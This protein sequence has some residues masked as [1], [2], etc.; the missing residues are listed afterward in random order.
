MER[1]A[2]LMAN[3]ASP[4]ETLAWCP[5]AAQARRVARMLSPRDAQLA[6][7][8]AVEREDQ[9][10]EASGGLRS[11]RSALVR[12]VGNPIPNSTG[13]SLKQLFFGVD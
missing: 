4:S 5:R 10:R 13:G 1:R 9:A 6:E 11:A 7:A 8:Y 3:K 12:S 2:I